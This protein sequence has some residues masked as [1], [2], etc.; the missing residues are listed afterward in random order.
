MRLMQ[1]GN[2]ISLKP[3]GSGKQGSSSAGEWEQWPEEA[4]NAS[5]QG[6]EDDDLQRAIAASLAD[7]DQG[8]SAFAT[9]MPPATQ[10]YCWASDLS[11]W[12]TMRPSFRQ[13]GQSAARGCSAA[14]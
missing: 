5:G 14:T 6:K 10:H 9:C 2:I 12:F 11:A 3:R 8:V 1:G 13:E 4:G 7:P